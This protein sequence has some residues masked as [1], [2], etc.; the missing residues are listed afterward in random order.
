MDIVHI[1]CDPILTCSNNLSY[2]FHEIHS[3]INIP[4]KKEDSFIRQGY[5]G[6]HEDVY[7][8][9]GMDLYYYDVNSA[10]RHIL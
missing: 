8:P 6:G 4:N 3:K 5:Y 7:Q 2:T 10:S 1:V 9:Y